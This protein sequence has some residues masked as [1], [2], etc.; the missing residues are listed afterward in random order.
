MASEPIYFENKKSHWIIDLANATI[1]PLWYTVK[2]WGA[3]AAITTA[4]LWA[5]VQFNTQHDIFP[6]YVAIPVSVGVTW[7]YL[8]GLAFATAITKA[9]WRSHLMIVIGALT[10][11]LFGMLYVASKFNLIEEKPQGVTALALVL[12]HTLPLILLLVIYTY[13]KRAYLTELYETQ[14]IDNDLALAEKQRQQRI[15]DDKEDYDR[16]VREIK[17]ELIAARERIKI[18]ALQADIIVKDKTLKTCDFCGS[19]CNA[20][21]WLSMKRRGYCSQCPNKRDQRT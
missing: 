4:V 9:S 12:A 10:E 6:L 8:S 14:Q 15:A 3:V 2:Q 13:C 5:S 21:S 7:T 19:T 11:A 18:D 16:R 20:G 1:A 17:L